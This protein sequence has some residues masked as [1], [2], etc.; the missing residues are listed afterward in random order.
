MQAESLLSQNI[1]SS[2]HLQLYDNKSAYFRVKNLWFFS[3][4]HFS[5]TC[6]TTKTSFPYQATSI[7]CIQCDD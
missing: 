5:L 7:R 6:W 3:H 4:F 2:P 1:V